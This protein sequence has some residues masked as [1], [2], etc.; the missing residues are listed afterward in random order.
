V[1]KRKDPPAAPAGAD[2]ASALR[3]VAYLLE[4]ERA[5][6]YRVR[7]FRRAAASVDEAGPQRVAQLARAGR[8]TDLPGIGPATATVVQEALA[9]ETPAYVADLEGRRAGPQAPAVAALVAR[10]RGDLHSHSD[11]SDGGSPIEE[12]ALAARDRGEEYLA[13]TDHSPRLTV[14]HGLDAG[15]LAQQLDVVAALNDRLAPFRILTGIE[16]DILLDGTLDQDDE[17]LGRLDVVVASV[18][19]KLRMEAAEMT[20][21]MVAAV[22]QPHTDILGHCTGRIIVGRGRPPSS[23][24]AD[25]VFEACRRTDTAV[26]INSRPERRDPPPDLLHRAVSAG[27]LFSIDTD[28]HAPGQLEWQHYGCEQAVEAGVPPDRIVT[29]WTADRVLAWTGHHGAPQ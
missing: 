17:L 20:S 28:A 12:M 7:A 2:P 26:E 29:T 24:D 14:A 21:R 22:E 13:L 10:L 25:V 8:L 19:S 16:V 27:C 15:R 11:W 6:T 5:E 3:R 23:F 18:H 1:T 4:A 9:G